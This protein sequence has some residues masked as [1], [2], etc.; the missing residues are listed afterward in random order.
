M[1]TETRSNQI[2]GG[3]PESQPEPGLYDPAH[4][5]GVHLRL[6][7]NG[8]ARFCHNQNRVRAGPALCGAQVSQVLS[9]GFRQQG[10]FYEAVINRIL[11]DLVEICH[12]RRMTVIGEFAV[13]GGI[14]S[15]IVASYN[16]Q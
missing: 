15:T 9:F 6:S 2:A 1:N 12:P 4:L 8:T 7:D 14:S 5:P 3:I 10:I 13:R 16:K 11:D